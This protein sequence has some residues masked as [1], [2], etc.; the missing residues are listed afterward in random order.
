MEANLLPC[1]A[2]ARLQAW[3]RFSVSPKE[4]LDAAP[5]RGEARHARTE[6]LGPIQTTERVRGTPGVALQIGF[7]TTSHKSADVATRWSMSD[8]VWADLAPH[9]TEGGIHW[10]S[11]KQES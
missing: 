11:E 9:S 8:R 10:L 2:E 6:F 5:V 4:H 1:N 3:V 7:F